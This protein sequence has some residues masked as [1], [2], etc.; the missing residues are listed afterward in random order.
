MYGAVHL[1]GI[2]TLFSCL[3]YNRNAN[4]REFYKE[5]NLP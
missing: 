1:F 2:V 5:R 4:K 3:T